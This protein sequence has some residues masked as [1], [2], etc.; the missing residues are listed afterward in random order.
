MNTI[1]IKHIAINSHIAAA[2]TLVVLGV[3]TGI[4]APQSAQAQGL[5]EFYGAGN[6]RQGNYLFTKIAR[7]IDGNYLFTNRVSDADGNYL[8]TNII[9]DP[10][11]SYLF[12]SSKPTPSD[13]SIATPYSTVTNKRTM[14]GYSVAIESDVA[15]GALTDGS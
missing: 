6:A 7:D 8:F 12:T 2:L 11:G 5:V 10:S 4:V 14:G 13:W 1:R 15:F 3:G 9:C